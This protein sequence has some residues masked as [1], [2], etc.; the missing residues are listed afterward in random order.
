MRLDGVIFH[1]FFPF[2]VEDVSYFCKR[3]PSY[4]GVRNS[5]GRG[6]LDWGVLIS[7]LEVGGL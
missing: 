3:A 5:R 6:W 7:A 4:S 1:F 2:K